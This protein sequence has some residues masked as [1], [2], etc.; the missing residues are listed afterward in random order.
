VPWPLGRSGKPSGITD[1]PSKIERST[2]LEALEAVLAA[3]ETAGGIDELRK[4]LPA[5]S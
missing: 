1:R 4:L 5:G 3:V 2:Q